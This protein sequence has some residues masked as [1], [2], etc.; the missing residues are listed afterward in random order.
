MKKL[1]AAML[2]FVTLQASSE[3]LVTGVVDGDT[4]RAELSGIPQPLNKVSIRLLGIDTPEIKGKCQKEKDK[5]QEAKK[6]LTGLFVKTEKIEMFNLHW[7]KYGSRILADVIFDGVNV[8]DQLITAGL[9]VPYF[10]KKKV[11]NWCQ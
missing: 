2:V 10:G 3:I 11:Y 8:S 9:A 7:D 6:F 1:L 4:L 5:A